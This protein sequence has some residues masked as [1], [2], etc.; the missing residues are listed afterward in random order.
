MWRHGYPRAYGTRQAIAQTHREKIRGKGKS[1]ETLEA[2]LLAVPKTGPT[3]S[4][5]RCGRG[6]G[7]SSGVW[8]A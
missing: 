4:Q 1:G 3:D 2:F 5:C 8:A 6:G 7:P